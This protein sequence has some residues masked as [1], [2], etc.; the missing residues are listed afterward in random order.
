V[1]GDWDCSVELGDALLKAIPPA[2]TSMTKPQ[3]LLVSSQSSSSAILQAGAAAEALPL[4]E[5]AAAAK[6]EVAV[7][8]NYAIALMQASCRCCRASDTGAAA[9]VAFI[10]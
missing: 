7:L 2:T 8:N 6:A 4:L 3:A 1:P 10:T 5:V 9:C